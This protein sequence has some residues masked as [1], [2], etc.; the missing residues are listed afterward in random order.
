[1]VLW[2]EAKYSRVTNFGRCDGEYFLPV[3]IKNEEELSLLNTMPLPA[4]FQVS[5]GNHLSISKYFSENGEVPYF[6]GQDVNDFFLENATPLRI[7]EEVYA[8]PMMKRSHFYAGDVLLSIVGTI[9]NL[10]IVPAALGPATGSCKIA[11]LRSKGS[12]SPFVLAAFLLSRFGQLQIK[13]NTRG[14]VQMGLILKDLIR[15]RVPL[16][17]DGDADAIETLVEQA[18]EA[19]SVSKASYTKAQQLLESALGLGKLQF[20]K[21][22][23]YTAQFSVVGLADSYEAGRIDAQCFSPQAVFYEEWLL[24]H[25]NCS[26]LRHVLVDTVKGRQQTEAEVGAADYSSIKHI[27]GHEIV[28]ASK[29]NPPVGTPIAAKNDLLLAITGATIGKIGMVYRYDSLVYSGDLLRLR[30]NGEINP[31]YL[32]LVLDHHLGQVQL[33]RWITGST[34]GHLSPKDVGRVLVPRLSPEIEENIAQLVSRSFENRL[35]SERLLE[36]A[37]TRVEHLIEEAITK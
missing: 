21:P 7:P 36:Q 4:L 23:G 20:D 30:T 14:A 32:L 34:N 15:V 26:R 10:S 17:Q 29:A 6:R 11:I 27:N 2:S 35:E 28:N 22:V 16:F 3:Y 33:I 12:Y 19:N 9:G 25:A 24:K 18:I 37:K 8:A 31:Y 5:D 13:R 1:M